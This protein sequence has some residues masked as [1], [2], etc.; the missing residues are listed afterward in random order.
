MQSSKDAL[1]A[2][3]RWLR[4]ASCRNRRRGREWQQLRGFAGQGAAW[5]GCPRLFEAVGQ[6]DLDVSPGEIALREEDEA[7]VEE[8]GHF[9]DEAFVALSE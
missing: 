8:V 9:R 1:G 2:R 5:G 7:V 4:G 6:L 3:R